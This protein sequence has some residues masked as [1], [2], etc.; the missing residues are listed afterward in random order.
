[1]LTVHGPVAVA[2][3]WAGIYVAVPSQLRHLCLVPSAHVLCC[4]WE[5]GLDL[6]MPLPAVERAGLCWAWVGASV[7][8]TE[9]VCRTRFPRVGAAKQGLCVSSP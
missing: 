4:E 3:A 6:A 2:V 9:H 5:S 1:M 7:N 8:D